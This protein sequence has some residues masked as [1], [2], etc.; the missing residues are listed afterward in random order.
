MTEFIF[1]FTPISLSLPTAVYFSKNSIPERER[2]R[3]RKYKKRKKKDRG[4]V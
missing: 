1:R 2:E 3:E 4:N